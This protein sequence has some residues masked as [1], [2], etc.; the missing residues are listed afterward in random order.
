MQDPSSRKK[1][2]EKSHK[3]PQR[4]HESKAPAKKKYMLPGLSSLSECQKATPGYPDPVNLLE[5]K[6]L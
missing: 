6:T 4:P 1:L 3:T 2:L 5:E